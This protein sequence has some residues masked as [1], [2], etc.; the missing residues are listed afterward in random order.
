ML[1]ISRLACRYYF[2]SHRESN[3]VFF[4]GKD[5]VLRVEQDQII[6]STTLRVWKFMRT[7]AELILIE[8]EN[9]DG[10]LDGLGNAFEPFAVHRSLFTVI[11]F[12]LGVVLIVGPKLFIEPGTKAPPFA[13]LGSGAECAICVNL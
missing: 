5:A 8:R 11:V 13:V 3:H 10:V 12:F 4:Q 1:F 9:D 6:H 2:V 7:S